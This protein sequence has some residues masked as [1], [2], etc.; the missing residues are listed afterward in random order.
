MFDSKALLACGAAVGLAGACT[1][2]AAVA[3]RAPRPVK[4]PVI[5]AH[6]ESVMV[7]HQTRLKGKN[8][9]S[10]FVIHLRECGRTFWLEPEEPCSTGNE[11]TV[12]TDAKGR[13][14]VPFH[15]ELCPEGEPGE[16]VT[17]R[18]CYIGEPQFGEDTG[19]LGPVVRIKVTYP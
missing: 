5:K 12:T 18:T 2:S 1:S 19:M 8:F 13:F 11:A 4:P 10:N 7:D 3:A 6:P 17:E 16:I 14:S 15:V 9:P